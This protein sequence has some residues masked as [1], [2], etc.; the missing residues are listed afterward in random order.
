MDMEIVEHSECIANGW[1]TDTV[2]PTTLQAQLDAVTRE[3]EGLRVSH[4][5]LVFPGEFLM[6]DLI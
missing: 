4:A 6:L 2:S 5:V 1:K 3:R